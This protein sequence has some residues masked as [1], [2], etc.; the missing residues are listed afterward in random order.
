MIERIIDAAK[1]TFATLLFY[2]I[3]LTIVGIV[4]S[5]F[6]WDT[7]PLINL[8][9][10]AKEHIIKNPEHILSIGFSFFILFVMALD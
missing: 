6:Q 7:Q 4:V 1:L 3:A 8:L 2:A 5:L 10:L 9:K